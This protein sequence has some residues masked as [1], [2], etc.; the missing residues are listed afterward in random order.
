ML[1]LDERH[2]VRIVCKVVVL[3]QHSLVL[4]P[5]DG[6]S[7]PVVWDEGGDSETEGRAGAELVSWGGRFAPVE[8]ID[9]PCE[10]GIATTGGGW[11]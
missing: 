8:C 11:A 5:D 10:A 1:R 3:D 6:D 7:V 2:K 4:E 9:G